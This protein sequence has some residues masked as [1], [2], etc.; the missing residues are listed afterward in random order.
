MVQEELF[1]VE[2]VRGGE[3]LAANDVACAFGTV[4]LS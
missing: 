1:G 3:R 2:G 4:S